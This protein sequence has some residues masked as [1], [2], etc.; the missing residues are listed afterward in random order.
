[1]KFGQL[2]SRLSTS[3]PGRLG[4]RFTAD[5]DDPN[6]GRLE[7]ATRVV[8]ECGELAPVGSET[9]DDCDDYLAELEAE[10]RSSHDGHIMGGHPR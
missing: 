5:L 6:I 3:E 8:C 1:M 7:P 10:S 4:A 2:G 9:C